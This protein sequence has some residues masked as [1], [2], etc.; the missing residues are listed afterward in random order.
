MKYLKTFENFTSII[1]KAVGIEQE[2]TL[3]DKTIDKEIT[4]EEKEKLVEDDKK[5][6]KERKKKQVA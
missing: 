4:E 5:E 6:E 2:M 1:P 3:M